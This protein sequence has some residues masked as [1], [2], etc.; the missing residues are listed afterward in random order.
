MKKTVIIILAVLPIFLI[1]TI[2]FVARILSSYQHI[3]VEKVRFTDS[4]FVE[5]DKNFTFE[6]NVGEEKQTYIKVYPEL[7]SNKNVE[8]TTQDEKIC[9]IDEKGV[10][11]GVSRGE[12]SV[13]VTTEDGSKT[14]MLSVCVKQD[15]VTGV[16]LPYEEVELIVG[17]SIDLRATV[18]PS[19]AINKQVDYSIS[20]PD[21]VSIDP[22]GKLVAKSVG[23]VVVYVITKDGGYFDSCKIVVKPGK[24]A[25]KFNIPNNSSFIHGEDIIVVN[26]KEIN[27]LDY[28]EYDEKRVIIEE[29][30]FKIR[31]GEVEERAT[32]SGDKLTIIGKGTIKIEA[33]F[34][35]YKAELNLYSNIKN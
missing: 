15:K 33:S 8:Y 20:D 4:N 34:G 25:L 30:E 7:A 18:E 3:S 9:T 26:I 11:K 19:G 28:L 12:T 2:S 23:V 32:L 5:L 16:M 35:E 6:L 24:P 21:V 22:N 14:A 17:E 10:I 13:M 31:T 29:V 27:L 1:I